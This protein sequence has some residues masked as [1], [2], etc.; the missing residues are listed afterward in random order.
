MDKNIIARI[1][2]EK[3]SKSEKDLLRS[4][5]KK[6]KAAD[7]AGDF[8]AQADYWKE[9]YQNLQKQC[10]RAI[11]G[12]NGLKRLSEILEEDVYTPTI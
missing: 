11:N 7:S 10:I 8:K 2:N 6:I 5:E 12:K 9:Q 4:L 1:I 3:E